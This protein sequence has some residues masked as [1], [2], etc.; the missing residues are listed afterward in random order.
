M[1]ENRLIS[2]NDKRSQLENWSGENYV[3]MGRNSAHKV[4]IEC[5]KLIDGESRYSLSL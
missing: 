2:V 4:D 3:S 5:I 1:R